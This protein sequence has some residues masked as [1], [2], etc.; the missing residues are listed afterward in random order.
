MANSWAGRRGLVLAERMMQEKKAEGGD[1]R[2]FRKA[3]EQLW[4]D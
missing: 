3:G 2:A 4:M 1:Q